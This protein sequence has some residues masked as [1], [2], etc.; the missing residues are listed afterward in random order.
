MRAFLTRPILVMALAAAAAAGTTLIP[1]GAAQAAAKTPCVNGQ[2]AG[3]SNGG[4]GSSYW[5]WCYA[6]PGQYIDYAVWIGCSSGG[7]G[8]TPYV[9]GTGP[10]KVFTYGETCWLGGHIT[11]FRIANY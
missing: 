3:Y 1:A 2:N 4:S 9:S 10:V 7:G 11:G 8:W 6:G 5:G